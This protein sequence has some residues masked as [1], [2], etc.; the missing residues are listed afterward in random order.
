MLLEIYPYVIERI[1]QPWP[2]YVAGPLIALNMFLLLYFGTRFGLSSNL[3][4]M[5]AI[6]G[7]GR[8][9]DFFRFDWRA[10][11]WNLAFVV[12]AILGGFIAAHW[13]TPPEGDL[14][15]I[16][17]ATVAS[18]QALNIEA[19]SYATPMVP[20]FFNWENLLTPRGFILL[21]IGG[22]LIGFGTRYAGGCT[23]GHAISGLSDLQLPSLIAVI[24]FFIGGL[25]AT[26][27]IFPVLFQ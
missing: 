1:S 11:L 6:G 14:V 27:L 15:H 7:A 9:S 2:W 12:G 20:E 17:E 13:L 19:A 8:F 3:R 23:S 4:T 26:H 16:S 5:C 22:F 24:G 18:L 21:V 10:Q 25:I